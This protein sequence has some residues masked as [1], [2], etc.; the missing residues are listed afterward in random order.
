MTQNR[1][2]LIRLFIS[3]L[4]NSIVHTILEQAINREEIADKYR[5]ELNNSFDI[6]KTMGHRA[7]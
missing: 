6:K 7:F 2:K 5:K 4:S 1:N 3:N